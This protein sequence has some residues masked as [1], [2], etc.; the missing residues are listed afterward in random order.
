MSQP[1]VF[2]CACT[3][4]IGNETVKAISQKHQRINLRVGA[5]DTQK[6]MEK[7]KGMKV[8]IREADARKPDQMVQA[9]RGADAALVIPPVED[10]VELSKSFIDSAKKAGIKF[11][12]LISS[13]TVGKEGIF[14]KQFQEIEK[15]VETSG[16]PHCFLRCEMFLSNHFMDGRMLREKGKFCYPVD[17][18]AKCNDVA[19]TDIGEM[20]AAILQDCRRH[21]NS[22]YHL[23]NSKPISMNELASIYSKIMGKEIKYEKCSP[24]QFEQNLM[25]CGFPK[26]Q[27]QGVTELWNNVEKGNCNCVSDDI[28]KVLGRRA[29]SAEDYLMQNRNCLTEQEE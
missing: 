12:V 28:Q 2:I 24:E 6:A 18:N 19:P 16:I 26:W 27:A 1:T 17:G 5:R 20:A 13:S 9:M 11:L 25:Q 7:F 10:R 23:T 29:M 3:G 14:A 21:D 8:D 15:Y 4:T 22:V